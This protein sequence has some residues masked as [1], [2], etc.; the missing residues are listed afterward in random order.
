MD[1]RRL[2]IRVGGLVL[3]AVAGVL[4]ILWLMGELTFGRG[5]QLA[6]EFSH[7][8]NVVAGAPVKLGGVVV[9]R[10]DKIVLTPDRRDADGNPLPVRMQL[11]LEPSSRAALRDD[12][13]VTIA[14]QGPLGE[15]YLELFVGTAREPLLAAREPIRGVDAARLE[16]V[17]SRLSSLL[18]GAT[19]LLD[20]NPQALGDLIGN[21]AGL[22]RTVDGVM[23]ENRAEIQTLLSDAA[24]AAKE[25]REVAALA[26]G[27]LM[28]GGKGAQLLDDAAASARALR[29]DL[30]QLSADA[31]KALSGAAAVTG[32]LTVE[33][34]QRLKVALAKYTAAGEKLDRIALRA[35]NV[36][37]R[38][39]AGEGSLGG[40]Y[41][42]PQLYQDLKVLVADLKRHPWKFLWKD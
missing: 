37:T 42:D 2:E 41:K 34:G 32:Q 12:T 15:P 17:A 1:E 6:V 26:R 3:A 10:V 4:A 25:L 30:P 9:G 18:E 31:K 16:L 27:Q 5:A 39:E 14:T 38:I 11:A 23:K 8:G 36:L 22:S 28:P 21:V 29:T 24:A 20:Q 40:M 35:E 7:S 33:D 19:R 13:Q